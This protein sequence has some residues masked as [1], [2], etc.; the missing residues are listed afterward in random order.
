MP[1]PVRALKLDSPIRLSDFDAPSAQSTATALPPSYD[2]IVLRRTR[3]RDKP[4]ASR[5]PTR[6]PNLQ[7][8]AWQFSGWGETSRVRLTAEELAAGEATV[9]RERPIKLH[10]ALASAI[11][12]NDV[13]ASALYAFPALAAS[14][15]VYGIIGLTIATMLPFLWRPIMLELASALP[16]R[17]APYACVL[18]TASKSLAIFAASCALMDFVV[19]SWRIERADRSGHLGRLGSLSGVV[20]AGRDHG[21][22][23]RLGDRG[24]VHRALH[25]AQ[26][27]RPAREH[28]DGARCRDIPHGHDEYVDPRGHRRLGTHGERRDRGQLVGGSAGLGIGRRASHL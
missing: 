4:K 19:R 7:D 25:P 20:P 12:A 23:P 27:R 9:E 6:Y 21:Q 16:L 2:D 28:V 14:S 10:A 5:A 11:A 8:A 15:G 26:P 24:C 18:N 3:S 22:H 1:T 13:F 17:G